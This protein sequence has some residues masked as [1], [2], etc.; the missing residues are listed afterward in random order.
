MEGK[1]T[2]LAAYGDPERTL[3]VFEERLTY[4]AAKMAIE[5]RGRHFLAEREWLSQ[6]LEGFTPQDVAAGLQRHVEQL[7]VRYVRDMVRRYQPATGR[8]ALAGGLFANVRLN[9]LVSELPEIKEIYIFP[10]MGDGG[11]AAGAALAVDHGYG[12]TVPYRLEDVFLGPEYSETTLRQAID[13]AGLP[14]TQPDEL[15]DAVAE[16]LANGQI[17]AR[18]DGRMEFGPRT[19]GNRSILC[20]A[21]D[22][23]INDRLNDK[24]RRTEFMPFAPVV[25]DVDLEAIFTA[26]DG[27]RFAMEFMTITC[28]TNARARQ[29]APAIV[30]VDGTARPQV[31]REETNPSLYRVLSQYKANTGLSVLINTSFNMHEEPIVESPTMAVRSFLEAELDWLAMGPFLVRHP[32]HSNPSYDQ[33]SVSS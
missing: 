7:V 23:T 6:A 18:F 33:A 19:L 4:N 17:V 24:L 13:E 9:Q 27:K 5:N 21:D 10:H 15:E 22:P 32:K 8:V 16:A 28:D 12:P 14:L 20:S 30:H 3:P 26:T 2:G 29:G 11:L 31:V 1:V 25:R